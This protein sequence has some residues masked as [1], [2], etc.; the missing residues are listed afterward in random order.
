LF[1]PRIST[2][3][4]F[5]QGLLQ[6]K[7]LKFITTARLPFRIV[8]RT[9]F[10]D[11]LEVAQLAESKLDI[12]SARTIRRLLDTTVQEQQQSVLS[13]LPEGS[14]ISI[15]LDCWTSPFNQAFMAIS[16][17]FI[18]Q[19]WNYYEVL[20]GFEHL[21]GSHTGDNLSETVIQILQAHGIADRVLSITTDNASNNNTMMTGVQ[22]KMQSLVLSGTSI[23]RVPCIAHVIQLSLQQLLGKLKA[24]PV[25]K[26]AESE[27][28]DERTQLLKSRHP[29]QSI[30]DTLKKVLFI[31]TSS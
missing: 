4:D 16:G 2:R 11:L 29:T 9:E 28:S 26:E 3:K 20:L 5:S 13:K 31:L 23:F 25:N 12:P 27:W 22:E 21:H 15:A 6:Q 8:E 19:D 24:V 14:R 30:V 17:Y 10:K 7:I 1:K 18:D